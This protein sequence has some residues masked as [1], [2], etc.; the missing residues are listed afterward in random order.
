MPVSIWP[1][2]RCEVCG[3]VIADALEG[4]AVQ[5]TRDGYAG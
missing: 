2:I 3:D 4:L 5:V 1:R